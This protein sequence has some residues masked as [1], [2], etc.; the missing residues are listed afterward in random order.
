MEEIVLYFYYRNLNFLVTLSA[1]FKEIKFRY[2]I[3][4]FQCCGSYILLF[5]P[6]IAPFK[7]R[8]GQEE[9]ALKSR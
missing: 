7:S 1:I 5:C 8:A 3:N 2:N 6:S 9:V 4:V